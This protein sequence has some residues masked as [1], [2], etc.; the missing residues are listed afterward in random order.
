MLGL[1]LESSWAQRRSALS[2]SLASFRRLTDRRM[3]DVEPQRLEIVRPDRSM[4]LGEFATRY[5]AT[6]PEATLAILNGLEPGARVEAGRP[7]KVVRGG[8]LP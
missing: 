3:I 6:A 5:D 4:S 2:G 8:K 1:A 7:Y